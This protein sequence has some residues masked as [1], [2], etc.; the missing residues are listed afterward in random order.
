MPNCRINTLTPDEIT[1]YRNR[2]VQAI[3]GLM[4][5]LQ[6]ALEI[7]QYKTIGQKW[8][9]MAS[10]MGLTQEDGNSFYNFFIPLNNDI[11][12]LIRN[13]NHN[14][15]NPNLYD[16][17]E[18]LGRPNKRYVIYFKNGNTFSDNPTTFLDA[19][20]H[21]IPYN[22]NALD[23]KDSVI[24]YINSLIKIFEKGETTFPPL[25]ITS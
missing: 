4:I 10:Y 5:C 25:P 16:R 8:K 11:V 19:E 13:A 12:F 9:I 3:N 1:K 24:A 6:H 14:N 22:V 18:Q 15:A 7:S 23:N 20:H 2:S 17:H 21:V